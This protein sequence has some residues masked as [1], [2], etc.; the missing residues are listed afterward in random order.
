MTRQISASQFKARCLGLMDDVAASGDVLV[1]TKNGQP[2][3]EL[4]PARPPRHPTPFGLHRA[5]RLIGDVLAPLEEP[6]D[7][8]V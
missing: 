1:I 5:T 3:A 2:V 8:L 4:H 6:W 7:A